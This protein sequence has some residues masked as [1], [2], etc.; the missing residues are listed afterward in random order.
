MHAPE[1][2]NIITL[3]PAHSTAQTKKRA[4]PRHTKNINVYKMIN[5]T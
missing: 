2:K 1:N 4:T 3:I 5:Y